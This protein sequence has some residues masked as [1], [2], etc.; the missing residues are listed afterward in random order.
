MPPKKNPTAFDLRAQLRKNK[1]EIKRWL[2][3]NKPRIVGLDI[4]TSS[5]G[6]YFWADHSSYLIQPPIDQTRTAKIN[7][8]KIN[9]QYLFD[10]HKPNV[11]SIED[12]SLSLKGSSLFQVA[13]AGGVVRDILFEREIPVFFIAPQTLKKFVLGPGKANK[14][15]G[16]QSKSLV[17]LRTFTRWGF[18]FSN[19]DMCDAFC[20]ARFLHDILRYVEGKGEYKKWEIDHFESFLKKRGESLSV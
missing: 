13:E 18:E 15:S 9:L 11:A 17:L 4:S 1:Y 3:E 12:Y 20:L 10:Q 14:V 16:S 7:T 8:A 19:H 5:S 6:V 2:E